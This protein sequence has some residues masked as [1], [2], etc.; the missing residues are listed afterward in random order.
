MPYTDETLLRDYQR[1]SGQ[2]KSKAEKY[3][4]NLLRFPLDH[5]RELEFSFSDKTFFISRSKSSKYVSLWD[6]KSEQSFNS[7]EELVNKATIQ[8]RTLLSV[9][10][11]IKI[12]TIF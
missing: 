8:N 4:K 2:H 3:I 1:L 11:E 9:W 7:V 12:Q 5:G 10:P 6:D